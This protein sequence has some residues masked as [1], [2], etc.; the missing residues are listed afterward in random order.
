MYYLCMFVF[1]CVYLLD[2]TLY[3]QE[4]YRKEGR[5]GGQDHWLILNRG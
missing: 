1:V 4:R 3:R 2:N 5:R